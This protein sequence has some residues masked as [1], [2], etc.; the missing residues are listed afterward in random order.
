MDYSRLVGLTVAEADKIVKLQNEK[1]FVFPYSIDRFMSVAGKDLGCN[2]MRI[3]VRVKEDKI[4][5]VM[6]KY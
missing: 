1:Y 4:I 3:L 2:P 5:E 6:G